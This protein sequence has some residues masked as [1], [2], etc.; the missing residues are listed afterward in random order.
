VTLV[1]T[2][3]CLSIAVAAMLWA[4]SLFIQPYLHGE[5]VSQ[6]PLRALVGGLAVGCFVTLWVYANTR[7]ERK[8][9][10]GTFFEFNPVGTK[11]IDAFDAVQRSANKQEDGKYPEATVSFKRPTGK[12]EGFVEAKSPTVPFRLNTSNM[13]TVA[14]IVDEGGQKVRFDAELNDAGNAYKSPAKTFR[15]A[16]GSRF[17]DA[18]T[19]GGG[20]GVIYAP[21]TGAVIVAI[22]LNLLLFVVWFAVFWPLLQYSSGMSL[23]LAAGFGLATMLVA[24]PLLF[25]LNA[26]VSTVAAG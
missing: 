8:D 21:S 2:F 7:A 18:G 19:D 9:K 10:Y 14:V 20:I 6:L 5:P 22:L 17:I 1:L 4:M 13:M 24:L 12:A 11:P 16:S 23:G 25:E 3:I 26:K 15:E